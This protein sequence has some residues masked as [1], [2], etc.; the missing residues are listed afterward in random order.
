[1]QQI[2]PG[3]SVV[4]F[5]R[6]SIPVK[7]IRQLQST[8]CFELKAGPEEF[9]LHGQCDEKQ[10]VFCPIIGSVNIFSQIWFA[11]SGMNEVSQQ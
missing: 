5:L 7:I 3:F 6:N 8:P 10:I 1:M 4:L 9:C 2:L 11:A